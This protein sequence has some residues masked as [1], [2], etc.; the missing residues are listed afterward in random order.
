MI[1]A[2]FDIGTNTFLMLIGTMKI[3]GWHIL[4]DAHA[5]ARLGEGVDKTGRISEEA[6]IRAEAIAKD[7]ALL[8]KKHH[9]TYGVGVATSAV[10]DAENGKEICERLSNVLGCKIQ[11]ISGDIEAKYS[12][13]GTSESPELK[14]VIDIGGG[15]TEYITG[16]NNRIL[17]RQSLQIGAVRLHERYLKGLPPRAQNI[18]AAR[19][20]VRK[21]LAGLPQASVEGKNVEDRKVSVGEIV[22]VGGT[23]TTLAAIDLQ[24][25]TFDSKRVHNHIMSAEAVSTMTQ[26]L[27]T[28][29]LEV[30]LQNP[31]IHPKRADILPAG[32]IILEESLAFFGVNSCKAS[33]KGLRYGVLDQSIF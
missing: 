18:E 4:H 8:C 7:F 3:D 24:L 32:A 19:A 23:F 16:E 9:V 15:S 10:R 28:S 29:T 21:Q 33:T 22:G 27:L 25:T 2:A 31:A 17:M 12:F 20:E 6:Y 1:T 13:I 5:I 14:T 26:Y 11:C 30:L